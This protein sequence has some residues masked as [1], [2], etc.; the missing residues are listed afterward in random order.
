MR[1]RRYISWIAVAGILLH[2]VTLARHN[3]IQ[4]QAFST[5]AA[6]LQAFDAGI[7]CHVD[8]DADED[9]KAQGLPGK[10]Q[11]RTTK[12]CPVCFGFASANAALPASDAPALRVPQ[13]VIADAFISRDN[14]PAPPAGFRLPPNRGPPSIG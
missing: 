14:D 1:L 7:I 13:T 10:D 12:P 6:L 2:A 5:Q 11:G 3:V 8:S 9:G 4:Y